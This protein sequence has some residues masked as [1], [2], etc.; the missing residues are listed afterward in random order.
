MCEEGSLAAE[1]VAHLHLSPGGFFLGPLPLP[2]FSP[3]TIIGVGDSGDPQGL[4]SLGSTLWD[5]G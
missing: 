1:A 5:D 4:C 2:P 3:Q